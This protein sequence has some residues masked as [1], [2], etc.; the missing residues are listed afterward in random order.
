VGR[1]YK[2]DAASGQVTGQREALDGYGIAVV[3]GAS[4]KQLYIGSPDDGQ[5]HA[6]ALDAQGNFQGDPHT[7]A[8]LPDPQRARQITFDSSG[9]MVVQ[10]VAFSY[11]VNDVPV[12]SEIRFQ[13]DAATDKWSQVP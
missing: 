9:V 5:I 2:V 7:V 3:T 13:Y 11:S 4:G 6:L 10:A 12:G 1:V 8:T